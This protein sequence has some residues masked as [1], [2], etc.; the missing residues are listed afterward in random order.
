MATRT[1]EK[2]YVP[3]NIRV[4]TSRFYT[5]VQESHSDMML[6]PHAERYHSAVQDQ[7][8]NTS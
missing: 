2:Y 4:N 3:D 1:F 8:E 6:K 7:L 5:A